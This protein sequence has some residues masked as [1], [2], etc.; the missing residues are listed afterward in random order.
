[1]SCLNLCTSFLKTQTAHLPASGSAVAKWVCPLCV[2]MRPAA[3]GL[4]QVGKIW[5]SQVGLGCLHIC[6]DPKSYE[7]TLGT[8]ESG[9]EVHRKEHQNSRSF[10]HGI[11]CLLGMHRRLTAL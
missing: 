8:L 10:E 5:H 11:I 3:R 6:H 9:Y 4:K 7:L 1:M 2:M